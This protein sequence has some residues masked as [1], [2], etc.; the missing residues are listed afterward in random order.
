MLKSISGIGGVSVC[1]LCL[2]SACNKTQQPAANSVDRA[3]A[4]LEQGKEAEKANRDKDAAAAYRAALNAVPGM[5]EALNNLAYLQATSTDPS[6][7]NPQEGVTNSEHLVDSA[8]KQFINRRANRPPENVPRPFTN[9][10]LPASFYQV[11]MINTLAAAYASAGQFKTQTTITPVANG[12]A[13][14]AAAID[15]GRLALDNATNLAAAEPTPEHQQLV[16]QMQR[17]LNSYLAGKDLTGL[18]QF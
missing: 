2:L 5:P 16:A 1:A 14:A 8:L 13:C 10:P 9:L 15:A 3:R 18:R 7:R 6:V 11:R 17:N 4:Q 12:G